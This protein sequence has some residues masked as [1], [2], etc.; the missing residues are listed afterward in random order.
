MIACFTWRCS[1]PMHNEKLSQTQQTKIPRNEQIIFRFS[2]NKQLLLHTTNCECATQKPEICSRFRIYFGVFFPHFLHRCKAL[3][4]RI[5][6]AFIGNFYYIVHL[7][8]LSFSVQLICMKLK[9][10]MSF[11]SVNSMAT[12]TF[13]SSAFADFFFAFTIKAIWFYLFAYSFVV[14]SRYFKS[15]SCTISYWLQN[16][17]VIL[18]IKCN[19]KNKN[20]WSPLFVKQ[21]KNEMYKWYFIKLQIIINTPLKVERVSAQSSRNRP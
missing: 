16:G 6:F 8:F 5:S 12:I 21:N 2:R 18:C 11:N 9:I 14:C 20:G 13:I 7:I 1:R 19:N 3:I 4:S 17:T 15:S 10:Q